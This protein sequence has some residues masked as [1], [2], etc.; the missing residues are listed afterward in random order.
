MD[1]PGST[2]DAFLTCTVGE[3]VATVTLEQCA[4]DIT[5]TR[6]SRDNFL[7]LISEIE[8][9]DEVRA[10]LIVNDASYS[11]VDGQRR[12][13]SVLTDEAGAPDAERE[14]LLSLEEHARYR[15]LV[16]LQQFGKPVVGAMQGEIAACFFGLSLSFPLRIA[17]SDMSLAFPRLEFGFP[18]GWPLGLYLR[19]Y[20][21]QG[22]AAEMMLSGRPVDAETLL[23]LG[24]L[25]EVCAPGSLVSRGLERAAEL[26]RR[27]GPQYTG[28]NRALS[29]GAGAIL[30]NFNESLAAMRMA[31]HAA[32]PPA[33]GQRRVR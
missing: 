27:A 12:L 23:E 31:L 14:R 25:H 16:R 33:A 22:R 10:L 5:T 2:H 26:G 15:I 3:G 11:G 29:P 13:F 19:R 1:I 18:P 6:N 28:V 17:A 32:A 24:L 20:V 4:L 7:A 9:M 30:D 21:G 8:R